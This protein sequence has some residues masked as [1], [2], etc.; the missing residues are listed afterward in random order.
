MH[1]SFPFI[2]RPKGFVASM[3]NL[4]LDRAGQCRDVSQAVGGEPARDHPLLVAVLPGGRIIGD[5]RLAATRDDVVIGGIQAVFGDDSL[6]GNRAA[7][8]RRFR[9]PRHRAGTALLL[10]A[11]NSDN[12]YHWLLDSLPRWLMLQAAGWLNYDYVL[13]HSEPR[14]FQDETL[15]WLGVPAAKR[16]RCSKNYVHNFD[17]LIVPS[18]PFP[19]AHVPAW[20]SRWLRTLQPVPQEGPEK[21]YLSRMGAGGRR[22]VNEPELQAA[23]TARGF[24]TLQPEQVSVAEQARLLGAARCIVA[25]HGAALTNLVFAPPGAAVLELFHPGH[26]NTCYVTLAQACGHRYTC[27]DG[28]ALTPAQGQQLTYSV[29]IPEVLRRL[30]SGW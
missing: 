12:Y 26:K 14:R 28:Q 16:L 25:P 20:V 7:Q 8:R 5:L 13:L 11:S 4:A 30:E 18:M 22:L 9:L 21:I 10:G 17:R 29:K 3:E 19:V 27:L 23:L 15:D 2:W 1:F 24:V 6:C